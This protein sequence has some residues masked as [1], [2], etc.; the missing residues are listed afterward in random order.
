MQAIVT[1]Y[2]GA[3]NTRGSR[4]SAQADAGRISVPWDH[5][6]NADENHVAAARAYA[7]KFGWSGTWTMG[8]LPGN[9]GNVFV[10][11]SRKI[12]LTFKVRAS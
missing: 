8:G 5:A 12:A 6:L 11:Q 10:C 1:K 3:T 7:V 9:V 4:V 2:R